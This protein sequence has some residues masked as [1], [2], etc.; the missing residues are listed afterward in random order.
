[1]QASRGGIHPFVEPVPGAANWSP[2]GPATIWNGQTL[3]TDADLPG[4]VDERAPVCGRV[5]ALA[6]DPI[7]PDN[8]I[9]IGTA[10]GGVWKTTD[11][12][13]NWIP[14]TDFQV[15]LAIGALVAVQIGSGVNSTTRIYA[16]TGEANEARDSFYG[17]GILRSDDA[18]EIWTL[19]GASYFLGT[20]I[21]RVVIDPTSADRIFV[22]CDKGLAMSE[23]GGSSWT[24]LRTS[25][26]SDVV[27]RESTNTSRVLVVAFHDGLIKTVQLLP[28]PTWSNPINLY[29]NAQKL[30]R[31]TLAQ[32]PSNALT[33]YAVFGSNNPG[34]YS[35]IA[36]MAGSTD[37]GDTWTT[38]PGPAGTKQSWYNLALAVHPVYSNTVYLGICGVV[39]RR[40]RLGWTCLLEPAR[41]LT[42]RCTAISMR[43]CFIRRPRTRYTLGTMAA[44]GEPRTRATT[45]SH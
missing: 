41:A 1:V 12:G 38:F 22:A 27:I 25:R 34:T 23:N 6:L 44:S 30:D 9:Y 35:A 45:G 36:G 14:K 31:V 43:S 10:M 4:R 32:A 40:G 15:S 28:Q 39:W 8:T 13:V 21:S 20:K 19:I 17:A 18:G 2:V 7:D 29:P 37:G 3:A 42:W 24:W 5:T 16:G 33:I 11:G 26:T